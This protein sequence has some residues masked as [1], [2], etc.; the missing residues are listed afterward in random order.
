[1]AGATGL[2][3][4]VPRVMTITLA[5][6]LVLLLVLLVLLSLPLPSGFIVDGLLSV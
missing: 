2:S 4:G 1:M 3:S 5:L 6:A